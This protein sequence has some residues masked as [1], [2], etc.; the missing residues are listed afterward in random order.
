MSDFFLWR[1]FK[2]SQGYYTDFYILLSN[3]LHD[4]FS[5]NLEGEEPKINTKTINAEQGLGV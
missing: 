5:K 2:F 3:V 4:V 1:I